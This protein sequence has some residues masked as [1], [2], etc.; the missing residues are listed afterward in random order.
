[1]NN[2]QSNIEPERNA[3]RKDSSCPSENISILTD[4][5]VLSTDHLSHRKAADQ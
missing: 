4:H 1:M 3:R 2:E 5:K